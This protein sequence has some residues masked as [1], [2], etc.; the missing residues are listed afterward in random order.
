MLGAI[1]ISIQTF[2]EE[3]SDSIG[4]DQVLREKQTPCMM[5]FLSLLWGTLLL[6]VLILLRRD[7]FVFSPESFPTFSIRALLEIAQAYVS[8]LA[9]VHADRSTFG[10][11]R[12]LTIPL[13]LLVDFTLGYVIATTSVLG[14]VLIAV[15][16]FVMFQNNGIRKRGAGLILFTAVNAV[17]T[18]SLYKYDITHFN[19]VA[20][21][22][23]VL[24]VILLLFFSIMV[25]VRTG[26]NPLSL[27]RRPIFFWQSFASGFGDTVGS[28]AYG[29]GAASVITAAKRAS[30]IFWS[31]LSGRMKFK[32]ENIGLKLALFG[33]MFF[34]LILLSFGSK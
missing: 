29:Y 4:K 5:A 2:F 21:E 18:I 11:L 19:T 27:L 13:L 24:G 3:I 31:I 8:T 32:E 10:L 1:L 23:F 28:F 33:V 14:I 9:I 17:V 7:W 25:F 12:T 26:E 6:G 22:Q 34:G 20:A 30:A 15:A 16:L